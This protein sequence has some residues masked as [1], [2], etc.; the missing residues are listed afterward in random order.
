MFRAASDDDIEVYSDTV[1]CFIR[2]CVEDVVPTKTVC[3]YPNQKPWINSDVRAALARTSAFKSGNMEE[4]KQAN[5]DYRKTIKAAKR[6]YKNKIE[7]QFNTNNARS[8]WQGIN[9]I[10]DFKRNK[11]AAVNNAASLPDEL[12]EFYARFE[13]H[14]TADTERAPAADAE[15]VRTLS[16]SVHLHLII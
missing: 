12:N 5:Y 13:A 2:K 10:T 16:I 7:G 4:Q 1:T 15:A 3:I 8:M 9:N 6:Q 14:N 11:T